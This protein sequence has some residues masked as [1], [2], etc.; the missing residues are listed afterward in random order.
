MALIK[1]AKGRR[2]GQSPSGYTRVFGIVE[3]GN[4]MSRVQGTVISAGNELETLI[5]ERCTQIKD[6]DEFI[7]K[8]LHEEKEGIWVAS[9][10]QVKKSKI[11]NSK[12]EPDFLAFDLI[13]RV[14]YVIEVKDGD[15]L[16]TK[17]SA[18][19]HV[20]LKNFT[21]DV[22]QALSFSFRIY[23]C[24]FN[25]NTKDEIFH[26]LKKKFSLDEI[27]TG[28]ELCVLF[29]I[30]YNEIVTIRTGDQT[31]NLEYFVTELL[32][33]PDVKNIIDTKL[34]EE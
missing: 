25:A 2:E 23:I 16:D 13:K 17:K 20:T 29:K 3:L 1:N 12:Y 8:T 26:G 30:D 9:K 21:N 15:Q 28:K 10:A 6:L 14:C 7:V 33:I 11:I 18:G 22:S 4:L 5:W 32:R 24:S 19:E 34:K 31:N 27:L